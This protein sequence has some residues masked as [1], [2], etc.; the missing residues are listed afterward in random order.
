MKGNLL[1]PPLWLPLWLKIYGIFEGISSCWRARIG[2]V[3][4]VMGLHLLFTCEVDGSPLVHVSWCSLTVMSTQYSWK[5]SCILTLWLRIYNHVYTSARHVRLVPAN[6]SVLL[7][8]RIQLFLPASRKALYCFRQPLIHSLLLRA[9]RILLNTRSLIS[10]S[11]SAFCLLWNCD[12]STPLLKRLT[13][14][15][16]WELF[17]CL[18]FSEGEI[19]SGQAFYMNTIKQTI[20]KLKSS[21]PLS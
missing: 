2:I 14:S 15:I 17:T 4:R 12:V 18:V 19:C 1:W 5:V 7:T 9:K 6:H 11:W 10:Y 8:K 16:C 13:K 21:P 3:G 20:R